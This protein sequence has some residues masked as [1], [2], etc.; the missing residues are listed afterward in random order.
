VC[1]FSEACLGLH[2]PYVNKFGWEEG[3]LG[4]M[5]RT[6]PWTE[7]EEVLEGKPEEYGDKKEQSD[8]RDWRAHPAWEALVEGD[9][10]PAQAELLR[11]QLTRNQARYLFRLPS[12]V[13]AADA[14]ASASS[15]PDGPTVEVVLTARDESAPALARSKAFNIFYGKVEGPYDKQALAA[16]LRAI[17]DRIIARDSGQLSLDPRKGLLQVL[18]PNDGRPRHKR[19]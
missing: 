4:P 2:H 5:P 7:K 13:V 11:L 18:P 16:W 19:A 9:G 14:G 8:G 10:G 1:E 3:L 6:S 17:A 12:A 15:V